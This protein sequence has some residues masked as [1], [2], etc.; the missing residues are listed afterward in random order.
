MSLVLVKRLVD[1]RFVGQSHLRVGRIMLHAVVGLGDLAGALFVKLGVFADLVL[2]G[3]TALRHI[4]IAGLF[5]LLDGLR[6]HLA[7]TRD[8]GFV[9]FALDGA[10]DLR[11]S[12]L[13]QLRDDASALETRQ[14]L[15]IAQ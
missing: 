15:L 10:L 5:Q 4:R 1:H 2:A 11:K 7:T 9:W 3:M 6:R 14:I 13:D 8:N 12:A